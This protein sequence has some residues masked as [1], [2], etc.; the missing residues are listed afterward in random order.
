MWGTKCLFV[1][2]YTDQKTKTEDRLARPGGTPDGVEVEVE[3]EQLQR[4]RGLR[5]EG[6][7]EPDLHAL[8]AYDVHE[9]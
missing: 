4:A 5:E 6:V 2:T 3:P 9:P 7:P 8:L 1:S